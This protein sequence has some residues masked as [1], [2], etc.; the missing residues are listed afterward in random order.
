MI[1]QTEKKKVFSSLHIE[2][3]IE[4]LWCFLIKS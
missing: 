4:A 2:P 3:D 1:K